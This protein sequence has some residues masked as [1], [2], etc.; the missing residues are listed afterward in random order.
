M[1]SR[2]YTILYENFQYYAYYWPNLDL[3][4]EFF[5]KKSYE[6]MFDRPKNIINK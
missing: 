2:A 4:M 5:T 3:K 1:I 6:S